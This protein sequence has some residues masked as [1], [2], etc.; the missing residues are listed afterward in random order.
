MTS[1]EFFIASIVA[2]HLKESFGLFFRAVFLHHLGYFFPVPS[3]KLW[4]ESASLVVLQSY[5]AQNKQEPFKLFL[6]F[7]PKLVF[8]LFPCQSL[9]YT[10]GAVL[11]FAACIFFIEISTVQ[12]TNLVRAVLTANSGTSWYGSNLT[13]NSGQK[14]Q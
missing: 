12:I 9:W 2:R 3:S 6:P 10:C 14:L 8:I 11:S 13:G 7:C 4:H 1:Q 5:H